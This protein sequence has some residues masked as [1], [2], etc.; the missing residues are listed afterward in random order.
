M[1][2]RI[3]GRQGMEIAHGHAPF[4]GASL[5]DDDG[6]ERRERHRGIGGLCGDAGVGPAKDGVPIVDPVPSSATGA[7]DALVAR[8]SLFGTEVRASRPL[9]QIATDGREIA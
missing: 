4:S 1:Q 5:H 7:R 8:Q 3:V 2:R 9:Q 6:V